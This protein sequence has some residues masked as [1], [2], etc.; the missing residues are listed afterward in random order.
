MAT[1]PWKKQS[2]GRYLPMVGGV[3]GK[4]WPF[5]FPLVIISRTIVPSEKRGGVGGKMG[6]TFTKHLLCARYLVL[7][8]EDLESIGKTLQE[9]KSLK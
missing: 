5:V 6:F 9:K 7:H 8:Q 4:P 2:I 1:D 3:L